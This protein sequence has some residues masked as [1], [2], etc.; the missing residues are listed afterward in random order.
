MSH[1]SFCTFSYRKMQER[2]HGAPK[3]KIPS[4]Y[5]QM[6]LK[7]GICSIF[8]HLNCLII[9]ARPD[10]LPFAFHLCLI[11]SPFQIQDFAWPIIFQSLQGQCQIGNKSYYVIKPFGYFNALCWQPHHLDVIE[12]Q[13]V[14][15]TM[16]IVEWIINYCKNIFLETSEKRITSTWWS[17][18]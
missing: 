10:Y 1:L 11:A 5:R 6:S 8:W 17:Q 16:V 3:H 7:V 18:E 4:I 2:P 13:M 14:M 15:I 9:H 12:E